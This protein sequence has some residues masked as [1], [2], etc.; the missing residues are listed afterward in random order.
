MLR[1]RSKC[2]GTLG[3]S[4]SSMWANIS[5]IFIS[6]VLTMRLMAFRFKQ[7]VFFTNCF[8]QWIGGGTDQIVHGKRLLYR[9]RHQFGSKQDALKDQ[10]TATFPYKSFYRKQNHEMWITASKTVHKISLSITI[11][12]VSLKLSLPD[13][14]NITMQH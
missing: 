8:H 7:T 2:I 1:T 10:K 9:K 3:N 6:N 11:H 12:L 13:Y 4:F 14:S 5:K